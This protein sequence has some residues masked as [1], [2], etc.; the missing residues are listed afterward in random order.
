MD[1]PGLTGTISGLAWPQ[2]IGDWNLMGP[3]NNLGA[4]RW[5]KRA[6]YQDGRPAKQ[7]GYP[8][9]QEVEMNSQLQPM[10][11]SPVEWGGI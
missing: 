7:G 9:G 3:A 5:Y 11:E 6:V 8:I 2:T 10:W 1:Y 4:W